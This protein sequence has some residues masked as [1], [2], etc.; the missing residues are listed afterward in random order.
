MRGTVASGSCLDHLAP[1]VTVRSLEGHTGSTS[2]KP[3]RRTWM[4]CRQECTAVLGG[5][6]AV[7]FVPLAEVMQQAVRT[8]LM[9]EA[10]VQNR[11]A[12]AS[13]AYIIFNRP[14]GASHMRTLDVLP[15]HHG[16][17][18]WVLEYKMG[19]LKAGER[20]AYL[21]PRGG[22][23]LATQC[24]AE[25]DAVPVCRPPGRRSSDSQAALCGAGT[26]FGA[27][28]GVGVDVAA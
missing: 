12:G 9:A 1:I 13:L 20:I 25:D 4:V 2:W 18:I 5:L 28:A 26:H 21:V 14:G 11:I 16:P 23:A 8:W 7:C 22:K 27:A 10:A 17:S 3:V 15:R 24:H 6:P 19:V